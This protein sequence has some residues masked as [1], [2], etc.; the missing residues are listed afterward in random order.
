LRLGRLAAFL[1]LAAV[2]LGLAPAYALEAVQVRQ[3]SA[4]IDLL[5]AAERHQTDTDRLQVSTAPGSDGIVR[6]IEVRAREP[7]GVTNW[8]VF[9]LGNNSDEQVDRL[10][11]APHYQMVGSGIFWPDLGSNRIV[12][13][14]P[15]QGFRPEQQAATDADVYLVTLDPGTTVTLVIEL[16]TPNLPQLRLWEPAAYTGKV[17]SFTLYNG[18]VIGIAGLLAMF[19]TILFVVKGSIMF[20]AAAALAWAVL[21][22]IGIEFNFWTKIFTLSPVTQQF[23]RASG[24]AILAATLIVFLFAYLNLGRWNVR[25][26][27]VAAGWLA[28]LALLVAVALIDPP[29]AAGIA[30]LSLLAVALVGFGLVVYLSTHGFDR[31]VLLIPTWFLLTVWVLATGLTVAGVFTN[32]LVAPALL[33]GLELIVMLIG[34]TVMQHAFAGAGAEGIV[35]DLERRALALT[36]ASDIVWDWDVVRDQIFTSHEAEQTLGLKRGVLETAA[37]GWVEFLHNSDRDRFKLALDSVLEQR[38]GR[39]VQEFRLRAEDGHY[40]W[41]KLRARPV[42]GTDGEVLRVVG[43]L[44]DITDGKIAEER[45]LHDAVHD[46]LTSLPN[47]ELFLDRLDAAIALGKADEQLRPTLIIIDLDRFKQVNSSVGMA[48]GDSILLT[49]AR[50][51]SRLLKPQD[52][53]ARISGDQ[54]GMILLSEREPERITAFADTIR[55]SLRAPIGFGARQIFL[56][57]SIGLVLYDGQNRNRGELLKDAELAMH[58]AKQHGADR[59]EVFKPTMRSNKVDA[60]TLES[61]LRRSIERDEIAIYYQPIVRLE[62]RAIAGFEALLRWNH[63]RLGRLGPSEFIPLAEE[64]GLITDLGR[65]VLERAARQLV[66][67]QRLVSGPRPLFVSVN[68]SSRQLLRQDLI[69][70]IKAVLA[71]NLLSPGTLK[72]ELT[73]S[74]VMENPELAA[75]MLA[76]IRELGAGLSLDDFGTGYSSLAYL[77]RFPFDTIKIDQQFVRGSGRGARPVIL[78]SIIALAHDLGME[79]VS[80]VANSRRAMPSVNR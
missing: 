64:T 3:G 37:A 26:S 5:P 8:V 71:R 58:H 78:R 73:E 6:R 32:D 2:C 30:R 33:G 21:A 17:N 69:Q 72:L 54:F 18:I 49:I 45:L 9:A 63:P 12:S 77:Q 55:R 70:E 41:F 1:T 7:R 28:F 43:T 13:I 22:Y 56:T 19:L 36:G 14:T 24:E 27:H 4:A 52:T 38:R 25:Y 11:V 39:I 40:L 29:I 44:T 53:L 48:V 10:I 59:I 15:S 67:W 51:L 16:T 79:V 80:S 47:R 76:R 61:D 66:A 74:L 50:R 57:A 23:A 35:N 68:V 62:D 42:V 34:F 46:N 75:Q 20:P 65:F 31:A 60:L